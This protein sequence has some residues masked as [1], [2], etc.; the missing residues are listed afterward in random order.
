ME[1]KS[2]R[3]WFAGMAMQGIISKS[4][5]VNS[6]ELISKI[7]YQIADAMIKERSCNKTGNELYIEKPIPPPREIR[8][9]GE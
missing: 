2:L 5:T 7:S 6:Y 1:K 3:D 4:G 9:E 8:R